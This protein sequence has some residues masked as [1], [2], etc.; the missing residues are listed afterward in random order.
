MAR[1]DLAAADRVL[2]TAAGVDGA[3]PETFYSLA[4]VKRARTMPAEATTWYKK[5]TDTDPGWSSPYVKLGLIAFN[6]GDFASA[7]QYLE[8]AVKLQP[9]GPDAAEARSLLEKARR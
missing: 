7:T 1:G 6:Q 9:D 3:S 4:E 5:A 8:R 2:T